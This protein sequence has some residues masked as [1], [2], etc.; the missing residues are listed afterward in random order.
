MTDLAALSRIDSFPYRHRLR[1]V[2]STPVLT[3]AEDVPLRDVIHRMHET[4]VSSI[5][6]VDAAGRAAGIFTERD[7]LRILSTGGCPGIEATLGQVM[8]RPVASVREDAFVYVALGKM[9]RMG[10]RHLVVVDADNRPIGMV[11]GRA[12]LK[13][14]A[15]QALGI[16]DSVEQAQGPEDMR[17]VMAALPGLA[18][19][20]LGEGVSATGIAAVIA[21]VVRDLTTRAAQLSEAAMAEDGWGGAPAPCALLV[22]GSGGR[23]ESL[24]VFDQDNAIVHAGTPAED[25]WFAELGKR[26]NQMLNEAGIPFCDGGVMAREAKWRKSLDEWK[27]EV[28]QWVYAVENQTVMYCDIF[29][30]FQPVWGDRALAEELRAWAVQRASESAFFM[31]YLAQHVAHMDPSLNFFGGFSTRQGRLNAKKAGLLPLVSA[32]RFRAIRAHIEA[33]GTSERFTALAA[34]G[35]LHDDDLRDFLAVEETVLWTLLDQQLADIDAGLAPS[36]R[37]DPRRLPRQQRERLRWALKRLQTLRQICGL[38]T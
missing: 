7:L 14:R 28:G 15:S 34:K 30:D 32:A 19:G 27:H 21:L 29:F 31:Q 35:L 25:V 1:E 6:G 37:I 38:G 13:V 26:V 20:L 33:T 22:L 2:M 23:G 3:A 4:R 16:G 5:V 24:L 18:R 36:A 8:T 9:T 17:A 11:T 12:L 10:Y